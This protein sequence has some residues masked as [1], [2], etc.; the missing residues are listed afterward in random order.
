MGFWL[1]NAYSSVAWA[2]YG[3]WDPNANAW[4]DSYGL[5]DPTAQLILTDGSRVSVLETSGSS[6]YAYWAKILE[7]DIVLGGPYSQATSPWILPHDGYG[8]MIIA[9]GGSCNIGSAAAGG[10]G[11]YGLGDAGGG[12]IGLG[13]L[14][15]EG[16]NIWYLKSNKKIVEVTV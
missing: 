11:D 1:W 9:T 3:I 12:V 6:K 16:T 13:C 4:K 15:V 7:I 5:C 14:Q 2:K 8:Y 10:Y